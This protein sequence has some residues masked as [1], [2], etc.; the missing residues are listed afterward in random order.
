MIAAGK[1]VATEHPALWP[2]ILAAGFAAVAAA[3]SWAAVWLNWRERKASRTPD[4][5][6]EPQVIDDTQEVRLF[7]TANGGPARMVH[8]NFVQGSEGI[9]GHPLPTAMFRPGESRLLE[10]T[11]KVT[12]DKPK[13]FVSCFDMAGKWQYACSVQGQRAAY[14][15]RGKKKGQGVTHE[16][17]MRRF[18]PDYDFG[19]PSEREGFKTIERNL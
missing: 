4:M 14:R 13:G 7:I 18:Y 15:L 5:H 6:I 11:L 10:T 1:A 17:I 9:Q 16:K 12:D 2:T 19:A 8:F 3:A